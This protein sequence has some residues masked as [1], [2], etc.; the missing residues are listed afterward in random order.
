MYYKVKNIDLVSFWCIEVLIL[1][2][3]NIVI[4]YMQ[5]DNNCSI[6]KLRSIMIM[7]NYYN[8]I[9]KREDERVRDG[10]VDVEY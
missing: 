10:N 2:Y 5:D 1:L 9:F 7:F 4:L 6:L 8:K 3:I